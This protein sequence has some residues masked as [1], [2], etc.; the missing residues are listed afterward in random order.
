M[1][2][3]YCAPRKPTRPANMPEK[4]ERPQTRR[5]HGSHHRS[6][7]LRETFFRL[8]SGKALFICV[9]TRR[10]HQLHSQAVPPCRRLA[11]ILSVAGTPKPVD[12]AG[13]KTVVDVK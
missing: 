2:V 4:G 3:E 7:H 13:G 1:V 8:A 12:S 11:S 6:A 10:P 5:D 9:T